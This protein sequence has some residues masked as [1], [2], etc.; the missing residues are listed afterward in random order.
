MFHL[1][2]FIMNI[3]GFENDRKAEYSV[4]CRTKNIFAKAPVFFRHFGTN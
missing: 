2:D 4:R 3:L 1:D